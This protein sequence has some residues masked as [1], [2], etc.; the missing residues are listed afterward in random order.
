MRTALSCV[1]AVLAAMAAGCGSTSAPQPGPPPLPMFGYSFGPGADASPAVQVAALRAIRSLVGR[2][3]YVRSPI[4]WNDVARPSPDWKKYDTYA[5]RVTAAGLRWLPVIFT[6]TAQHSFVAP[7]ATRFGLAGWEA[8]V[9]AIVA[10]YGPNG[11]YAATHPA[12]IAIT[13]FELWNEPNT[14]TGNAN[15][16]CP[17]CAMAPVTAD[18]IVAAGARAV[19]VQAARMGFQP[20][21]VGFALGAI[22]LPYL[23]RL[24]AADPHILQSLDALSIHLYMTEPPATCPVGD[25]AASTHC[26]RSLARLRHYLNTVSPRG[27]SPAIAITEGGYAGSNSRCRPSYVLSDATQAR[28]GTQAIQW[29]LH[30][31]KLRVSLYSPFQPIDTGSEPAG[32][33]ARWDADAFKSS[34]GAVLPDGALKPWGLAYRALVRRANNT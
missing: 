14:S 8:A 7:Q 15:P 4:H 28:Y 18:G 20:T 31:P 2:G 29:I 34:L 21:V 27:H 25:S 33:G 12:F 9:R 17:T 3:G 19:H 23:H 26:I 5:S 30:R 32:C 22:D 1:L 11:S 6:S 16:A 10:R 24:V 13:T